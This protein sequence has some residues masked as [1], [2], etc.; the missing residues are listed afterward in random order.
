MN[1][2]TLERIAKLVDEMLRKGVPKDVVQP[3]ID[4]IR[5]QP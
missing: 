3:I 1:Q 5:D 4:W 2:V